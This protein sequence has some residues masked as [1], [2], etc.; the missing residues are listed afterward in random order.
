MVF[1][2]IPIVAS[3]DPNDWNKNEAAGAGLFAIVALV[4]GGISL[5]HR[6]RGRG[7]A[8]AAVALGVIGLLAA[9][10]SQT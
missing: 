5:I 2:I 1:S 8:I 6:H 7:M 3:F 9:I 4:L 10:G